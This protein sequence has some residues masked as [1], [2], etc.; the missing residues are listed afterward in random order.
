MPWMA[1]VDVA[2]DNEGSI[3]RRVGHEYGAHS[4]QMDV[5]IAVAAGLVL[6]TP[7]DKARMHAKLRREVDR[8]ACRNE[9]LASDEGVEQRGRYAERVGDGVSGDL[10]NLAADLGQRGYGVS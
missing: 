8:V 1:L 3:G 7:G 2:P 5:E 6:H 10:V 9:R 4:C